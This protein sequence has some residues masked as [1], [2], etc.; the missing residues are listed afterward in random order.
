[1]NEGLTGI[2]SNLEEDDDDEDFV[3]E[4]DGDAAEYVVSKYYHL[5]VYCQGNKYVKKDNIWTCEEKIVKEIVYEW[6]YATPMKEYIPKS[7]KYV[8][9][10][11]SY[12]GSPISPANTIVQ[13]GCASVQRPPHVRPPYFTTFGQTKNPPPNFNQWDVLP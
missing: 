5:M 13:H 9:Y 6:I 10:N 3:L 2:P 8:F 7:D 1:M 11:S 12:F 4:N